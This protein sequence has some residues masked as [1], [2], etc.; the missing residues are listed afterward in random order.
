MTVLAEFRARLRRL[1][2]LGALLVCVLAPPAHAGGRLTVVELFTSQGCPLCPAAD[3]FLGELTRRSDVLALSF[4]VDYW[5]YLGWPDPFAKATFT[6]RQKK[7]LHE[8]GLPYVFTPQIV[9]DGDLHASGRHREDVLHNIEVAHANDRGRID[10][11]LTRLGNDQMRIRIPQAEPVY[12]DAA[13]VLLV[14]FDQRRE[15]AVT[16]GENAGKT[17]VNYNVVRVVRP[18]ADW[19]GAP[20][21]MVERLAELD[22]PGGDHCAVIVQESPQGRIL[23]A[24][25]LD[26]R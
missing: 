11:S 18:I 5:D 26:M 9:V 1:V 14:R 22:S 16:R 25:V 7:Y 17:L 19:T 3:A 6:R 15:T 8:F 20:I 13:E 24:A 10:V 21:D 2:W 12:R 23:G 4:H